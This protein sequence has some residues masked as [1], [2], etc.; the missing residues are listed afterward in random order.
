ML[1]KIRERSK[2]I[3]AYF[4]VGLIAIAFSLWGMDS[5]FTAMRGDPN[6]VAQVN[7]QSISQFQVDQVAQQQMRQLQQQGQINLEQVDMNLLRQFALNQ[8]IQEQLLLQKTKQLNMHIS[9][10]Q[11]ER[12][13]VRMGV[14]Q[15]EEGR[16]Q[17]NSFSQVLSQQGLTPQRFRQQLKQDLLNQQLL[18][19]LAETEFMLAK[20]VDQFQLLVG[21]LRD[22]RYKIIKVDDYLSQIDV[23]SEQVKNFYQ[24]QAPNYLTPEQLKVGYLV[25]DPASLANQFTAT[26]EQLQAEYER[27]LTNLKNQNSNF[28]A[29][30]ILLTY[31][32]AQEKQAAI[33]RLEVVKQA[34]Q[35]GASFASQAAEISEDV[36]TA[37]KGGELGRIQAGS[38]NNSFEEA[39]FAL[40]KVGDL[41]SVVETE[42]GLHLIQLTEKESIELPSFESLREELVARVIAQPVR[43][44]TTEKLEQLRNLS[45]SSNNLNEVAQAMSLEVQ[46]SDWLVRDKL[47][48]IWAEPALSK[49]LF[50]DDLIKE[51]WLTEPLRLSDGRYLV[52]ARETYQ[53]QKQQAL[54]EVLQQVTT[55]LKTQQAI[56]LV[57]KV[58]QQELDELQAKQEVQGEWQT[59]MGVTRNDS[60]HPRA[61]TEAAFRL[62]SSNA[63]SSVRLLNG[64]SVLI[65]LQK[66]EPGKVSTDATE[67]AQLSRALKEDKSYQMQNKFV[68]QLERKANIILR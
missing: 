63:S 10:R 35:E 21:Q 39:L 1:V 59:V 2:G 17:Q 37:N 68:Q 41:S 24:Q 7:K 43:N 47:Q 46:Q 18:G 34:V 45:F 53:P 5:L 22:Y 49:A 36:S 67:I 15:D 40:E 28:S 64:D 58:A 57:R 6:E 54:E 11:L 32:N 38:L 12:Q 16:F 65:E 20:E 8:L 29:A 42:F 52:V 31:K 26:E 62:S 30:H 50:A 23:S 44:A 9:D 27:Y 3:V 13:I 19:G 61:I 14:F 60:Y 48:G 4:L 25:F 55:E 66:V 51:G 33:K 56:E